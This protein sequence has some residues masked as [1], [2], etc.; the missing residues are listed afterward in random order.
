MVARDRVTVDIAL[1]RLHQFS[2]LS[3]VV[4][5]GWLRK[6]MKKD[7]AQY[8]LLTGWLTTSPDD[9]KWAFRRNT[10]AL[11]TALETLQDKVSADIWRK[12]CSKVLAKS[13][14]AESKGT[15]AELS[16]AVFLATNGVSFGMETQLNPPK[17]VDFSLKFDGLD[18][19]HIE[20]QS[21]AESATSQQSS[22]ASAA[23]GGLPV[24][25][26]FKSEERRV[27]GKVFDKTA[28][29]VDDQITLVALDCTAIPEHG[30]VGLGTIPDALDHIFAKSASNLSDPEQAIRQLVDGVI[31]CES[32]FPNALLPVR[33]DCI[34]NNHSKYH[35]AEA[36]QHFATIW[37]S[38]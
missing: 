10:Q 3:G 11:E 29:L 7:A 26:N 27:I 14:R 12:L 1:E 36:L 20:M 37:S 35:E 9:W 32:D 31:W 15:L 6:Q 21:L 16:L 30:G 19:V 8:S 23:W 38:E 24:S 4:S 33:R 18:D 2:C 17:D 13:D 28:K 22:Q 25:I 5:D 34:M